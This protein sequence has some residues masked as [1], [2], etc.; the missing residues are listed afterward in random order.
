MKFCTAAALLLALPAFALAGVAGPK[1]SIDISD[2]SLPNGVGSL[3]LEGEYERE[4]VDG[5]QAGVVYKF[6]ESRGKPSSLWVASTSDI[7]DDTV[8]RARADYNVA[9][10]TTEIEASLERGDDSVSMTFDTGSNEAGPV[11][12]TKTMDLSGRRVTLKPEINV[13]DRTGR[14]TINADVDDDANTVAELAMDQD[15]DEA[16]LEVSHKLDDQNTI[17]PKVDL[18]N[19]D[20]SVRLNRALENGSSLELTADRDNVDWEISDSNAWTVKGNVP[21]TDAGKSSIAFKR[22]VEL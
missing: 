11:K 21:L 4:L 2:P 5:V 7:D 6:N 15:G 13:K 9:S 1:F 18:K 3:N 20:I 14:I 19:G 8:L 22:T 17:S 16:T 12:I 10:K